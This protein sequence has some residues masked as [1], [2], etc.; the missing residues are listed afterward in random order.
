MQGC[1]S[2]GTGCGALGRGAKRIREGRGAAYTG[3]N[4]TQG[5]VHSAQG[6]G[7]GCSVHRNR[8]QVSRTVEHMV[9]E[10]GGVAYTGTDLK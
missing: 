9:G 5:R 4:L 7:E 2:H 6:R 1:S 10:E 3:T 8:P